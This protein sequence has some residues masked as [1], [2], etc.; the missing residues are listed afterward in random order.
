M[1]RITKEWVAKAE[2]DWASAQREVRARKNPNYDAACFHAQQC[3]E[4]Y[5]KARLQEANL[6]FGKTHDLVRLLHEV[7]AV[8][9]TWSV[10][11]NDL[12]L[13]TDFAVD[14]R[15]PGSSATRMEAQDA[16][17]SC[18]NVRSV[19]RKSFRLKS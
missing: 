13:L 9:A 10:L 16:L 3:A 7:L 19:I 5:L 18:Q 4:K 11:Q 12:I 6:A 17:K 8:E 14:Y 2:G 1:K 15:Y